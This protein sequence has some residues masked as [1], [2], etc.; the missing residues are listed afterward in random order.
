MVYKILPPSGY[1][2]EKTKHVSIPLKSGCVDITTY[3][4]GVEVV[5]ANINNHTNVSSSKPLIKI[6]DYTFQVPD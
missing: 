2:P 1:I 3:H 6:D 5:V 4:N